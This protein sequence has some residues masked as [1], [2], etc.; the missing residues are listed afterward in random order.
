MPTNDSIDTA[1]WMTSLLKRIAKGGADGIEQLVQNRRVQL[2]QRAAKRELNQFWIRLGKTAY[3][4][5][6]AGELDH[7]AISKAAERIKDYQT[8]LSN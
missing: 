1:D 5:R 6:E 2:E 3:H 8:K 4:L 7:P